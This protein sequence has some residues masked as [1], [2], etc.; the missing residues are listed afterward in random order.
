MNKNVDLN[1]LRKQLQERIGLTKFEVGDLICR[2]M[3]A[4]QLVGLAPKATRLPKMSARSYLTVDDG[5]KIDFAIPANLWRFVEVDWEEISPCYNFQT[6]DS[7]WIIHKIYIERASAHKFLILQDPLPRGPE[8][9]ILNSLDIPIIQKMKG[10]RPRKHDWD[11]FILAAEQW[12]RVNGRPS[13][14]AELVRNMAGWFGADEPA[15]S[16]MKKY[17]R[18]TYYAFKSGDQSD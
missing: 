4:G 15:D 5:L 18:P 12:M 14:L 2:T 1:W 9:T 16:S 8:P 10:G 11:E 7:S 17:L 13:T 3:M 6:D